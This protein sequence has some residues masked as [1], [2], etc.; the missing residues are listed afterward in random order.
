MF[1]GYT[2][3]RVDVYFKSIAEHTIVSLCFSVGAWV[4]RSG[5]QGVSKGCP[6][7]LEWVSKGCPVGVHVYVGMRLSAADAAG[8]TLCP[9]TCRQQTRPSAVCGLSAQWNKQPQ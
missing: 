1:P 7:D 9:L 8:G 2:L 4:C 5:V 3:L 6:R